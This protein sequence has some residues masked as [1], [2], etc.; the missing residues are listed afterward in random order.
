MTPELHN[1][2]AYKKKTFSRKKSFINTLETKLFVQ[3]CCGWSDDGEV[4]QKSEYPEREAAKCQV[5]PTHELP[6]CP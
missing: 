4:S 2:L 6:G 1:M 3:K 5:L